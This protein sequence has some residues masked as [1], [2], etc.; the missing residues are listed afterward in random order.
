ML[1]DAPHI[2]DVEFLP[3]GL[4]D[5]GVERMRPRLQERIDAAEARAYDAILLAYGLCNNGTVGLVA[6]HAPLVIPKAHD[7][8]TLFLGSRARYRTEFDGHPGTYYRTSGWIEREDPRGTGEV[9][10]SERMGLL[11]PYD[12][13]VRQYG[14]EN[15]AYLQEMLG[16]VSHYNR[17]VYIN[18]GIP[19][20]ERFRAQARHEADE[21]QWQFEELTGDPTLLRKLLY[22]DWD[23]NFLVVPPGSTLK[24]SLD[25]QVLTVAPAG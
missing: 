22:G 5:L 2:V 18:M 24:P 21:R 3:K 25:E 11:T 14:E 13:L 16:G 19:C 12:D 1:V 17:L 23:E 10:I 9:T 15:A 20:D 7:C 4:H 6:R 8:I